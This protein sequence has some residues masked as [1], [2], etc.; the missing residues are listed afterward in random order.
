M[1]V[2]L[3]SEELKGILSRHF[4]CEVTEFEVVA[5]DISPLGKKFRESITYPLLDKNNFVGNIKAIRRCVRDIG[6]IMTLVEAKWVIENWMKF[7]QFVDEYNRLP[8]FGYGSGERKGI[9]E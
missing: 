1:K 8:A 2:K 9:L 3:T 4:S 7:L 6:G 5:P